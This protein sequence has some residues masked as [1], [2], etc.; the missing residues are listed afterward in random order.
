MALMAAAQSKADPL[1]LAFMV[2]FFSYTVWLLWKS[3]R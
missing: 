3:M 1:M 2:I